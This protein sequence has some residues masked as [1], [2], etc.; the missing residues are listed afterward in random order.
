M[1]R[2]C[3]VDRVGRNLPADKMN[4]GTA[5]LVK[6]LFQAS[7]LLAQLKFRCDHSHG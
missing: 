3:V 4:S 1:D 7:V 5:S 2:Q 6:L